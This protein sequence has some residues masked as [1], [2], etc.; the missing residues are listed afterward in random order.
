M[1][2]E[3]KFWSGNCSRTKKPLLFIDTRQRWQQLKIRGKDQAVQSVNCSMCEQ[4]CTDA[5]DY[6][7]WRH[8][9]LLET[10]PQISISFVIFSTSWAVYEAC[11]HFV[12]DPTVIDCL[13]CSHVWVMQTQTGTSNPLMISVSINRKTFQLKQRNNW[14]LCDVILHLSISNNY[15][16]RI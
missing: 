2:R 14:A 9:A 12:K 5:R 1:N 11:F 8:E 10:Q 15:S 7:W 13:K 16:H 4:L 6:N 3:N